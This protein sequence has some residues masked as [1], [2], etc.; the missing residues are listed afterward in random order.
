MTCRTGGLGDCEGD[1]VPARATESSPRLNTQDDTYHHQETSPSEPA[2]SSHV[3]PKTS[4]VRADQQLHTSLD[5]FSAAEAQLTDNEFTQTAASN[6]HDIGNLEDFLK[7]LILQSHPYT[8]NARSNTNHKLDRTTLLQA[9]QASVGAD[10]DLSDDS[11]ASDDANE[12]TLMVRCLD[13]VGIELRASTDTGAADSFI[14]SSAIDRIGRSKFKI[15]PIPPGKVKPFKNPI[16]PD[17]V[18]VPTEFVRLPLGN[19]VIGLNA[20]ADLKIFELPEGTNGF[21]IILG[22]PFIRKCG[23]PR[24]LTKVVV[25]SQNDPR[26]A[27]ARDN[28]FGTILKGKESKSTYFCILRRKTDHANVINVEQKTA[29]KG[30]DQKFREQT[31]ATASKLYTTSGV[32]AQSFATATWGATSGR[33]QNHSQEF[34]GSATWS[35]SAQQ[36][37][38]LRSGPYYGSPTGQQAS[39]DHN[40]PLHDLP[41]EWAG[42]R[43]NTS[44]T[45]DTTNDSI[46]SM[47][48]RTTA[49]SMSSYSSVPTVEAEGG[50]PARHAADYAVPQGYALATFKNKSND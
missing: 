13:L 10:S 27:V 23:G 31:S 44:S 1:V 7:Q 19:D 36:P 6:A 28:S 50:K 37:N 49:S 15:R 30:N 46:F 2:P 9:Y 4:D 26:L 25:V 45:N 48:R 35:T 43:T 20:T 34:S 14:F 42:R 17:N 41:G 3:L 12:Y 33:S 18:I 39:P 47:T 11:E 16:D 24:F 5:R 8:A 22:R 32:G 38:G 29:N 21:E 40:T